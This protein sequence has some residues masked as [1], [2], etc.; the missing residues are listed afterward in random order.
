MPMRPAPDP[1][2]LWRARE[3]IVLLPHDPRW[4]IDA[5]SECARIAQACAPMVL[6]VEHIGSTSI[7][8][9][10]AKPVLDL[11]PIARDFEEAFACVEPMRA[12][13]YWYAGEWGISG[14]H[15]FVKGSPRTHHA[16][17]LADGS[18]EAR[19]HL[20]LRDVLR[21]DA[22]M[23]DRYA[24]LKQR[25]AGEFVDNREAYAEAKSSFMR[26]VFDRAGVE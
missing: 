8:D 3:T 23:R 17:M 7:P 4:L 21:T 9:L 14:R 19:R 13:G 24:S 18:R 11:M 2:H 25:L 22:A 20:A 5:A 16:H 15:F 12:L 10:I 1:E 6:R 26:E